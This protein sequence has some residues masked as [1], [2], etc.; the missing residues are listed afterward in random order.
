M[1]TKDSVVRLSETLFGMLAAPYA[2]SYEYC[3]VV[4]DFEK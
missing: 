3:A 2:I 1:R 4:G